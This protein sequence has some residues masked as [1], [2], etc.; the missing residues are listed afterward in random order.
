MVD[1]GK[2]WVVGS[3]FGAM[4]GVVVGLVLARL[5]WP[6]PRP[7]AET[8]IPSPLPPTATNVPAAGVADG[9][10]LWVSGLYAQDA[11][12]ERARERLA[13]LDIDAPAQALG[14]LAMRYGADGQAGIATDLATLAAALGD[15]RAELVAYVATATAT[16]TP[17]PPTATPTPLPPTATPTP[18]PTPAPPTATPSP[19]PVATRRPA[20][21]RV[22]VPTLAPAEP[23][24]QPLVWDHRVDL[25]SPPV[26]LVA[27]DV[28]PGQ[29]YWRLVRLEWW[30][31]GEGGNCMIYATTLKQDGAPKWGQPVVFEHGV[32]EV[33]YT[34]PK[35]G[36][37]YGTNYPMSGTLNSYIVYV[38]GDLPSDRVT[39]LGLGEWLGGLDHTTF[40]LIFQ[41]A[42]K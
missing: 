14:D 31:G 13:A 41:L 28:A 11:D 15:A 42:R 30:K 38:G 32:Q 7:A 29:L 9:A 12:L 26:R 8:P 40:V 20:G 5:L 1:F 17:V 2:R 24:P 35:P 34:D 37:A 23:T 27:A 6:V 33:L 16:P 10:L 25:L 18:T 3:L 39:G 21:T 4:L 22:P 19:Q 36:E